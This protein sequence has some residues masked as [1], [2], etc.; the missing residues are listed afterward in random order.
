MPNQ[1]SS[2]SGKPANLFVDMQR[3]NLGTPIFNKPSQV[4]QFSLG[5]QVYQVGKE[6]NKAGN[7]GNLV[8][9]TMGSKQDYSHDIHLKL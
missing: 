5:N 8:S 7:L 2:S 1:D 4:Q 3:K 6:E 9:D